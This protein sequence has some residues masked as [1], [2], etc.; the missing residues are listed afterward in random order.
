MI[1]RG[2]NVLKDLFNEF[3]SQH[4]AFY[5]D[6]ALILRD[7]QSVLGT[8]FGHFITSIVDD[9]RDSAPTLSLFID[10][11]GRG[12]LG[13]SSVTP[14]KRMSSIYRY[15]PSRVTEALSKLYK[16][17]FPEAKVTVSRIIL[18]SPLR[19]HFVAFCGN[20]RLLKREMLKAS[21][22]G[23]NFY[24]VAEKMDDELF[25]FYCKYFKRW[26]KL[27]HGEIFVYPTEDRVKIVTG[28]PRL[29][30]NLDLSI[31]I[32]LSRLFRSLVVKKQ[33]ILRASNVSPDMNFSG[34]A[35]S[36]YEV[37]LIDSLE[38]YRNLEPFYEMYRKSIKRAIEAMIDSV[39]TLPFEEGFKDD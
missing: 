39:K 12:F 37:D 22:A 19:V 33:N 8:E 29:S 9:A 30:H 7:R 26:V 25:D 23:R 3:Y 13:L 5:A 20:E 14:M 10:E 21:L 18:Q 11:E 27:R 15:P 36:A 2:P 38:V 31:I 17:L 28:L 24:K 6:E 16:K 1:F 34:V 35:T 32:E 4:K